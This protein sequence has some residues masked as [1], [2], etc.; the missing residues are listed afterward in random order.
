M[1]AVPALVKELEVCWPTE[2]QMR[3][4]VLIKPNPNPPTHQPSLKT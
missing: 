3:E 2:L 4:E 1:L